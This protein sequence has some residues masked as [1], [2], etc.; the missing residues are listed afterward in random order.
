VDVDEAGVLI[1]WT[2]SKGV[3]CITSSGDPG[4]IAR[5]ADTQKV[6]DLT[7][8]EIQEIDQAGRKVHFRHWVGPLGSLPIRSRTPC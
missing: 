4:R 5:M 7:P 6:R 2:V 1:L 3:V 8:E